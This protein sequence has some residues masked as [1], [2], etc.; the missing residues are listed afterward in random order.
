MPPPRKTPGDL[1]HITS[2]RGPFRALSGVD[3]NENDNEFGAMADEI[4]RIEAEVTAR[5]TPAEMS[6][7]KQA[8]LLCIEVQA[9]LRQVA[10]GG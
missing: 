8:I 2:R 5:L 6:I 4:D 10:E 7:R 1:C 9:H 3:D